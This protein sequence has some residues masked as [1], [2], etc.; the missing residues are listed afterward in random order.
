MN[1]V[2]L[3]LILPEQDRDLF[4]QRLF[5]LLTRQA[6]AYT[7]GESSSTPLE[8]AN[9]LLA[10]LSFTLQNAMECGLSP[11][12]L[13]EEDLN[14]MLVSGRC[15]IQEKST[16][17]KQLWNM[18]CLRLPPIEN[19]SMTDTLKN[20]RAFWRRY[21]DRFFA[22]ELPCDIDYQL[23]LPV[24]P[25]AQGVDYLLLYLKQLT[26][27][28]DFLR[29]YAAKDLL[30]VLNCF[31]PDFHGLLINLYEPVAT[32]AL[33]RS[34]MGRPTCSLD[35]ADQDRHALLRL[36][37]SASREHQTALLRQAARETARRL[38]LPSPDAVR[39]L[40]RYAEESL[41]PRVH[42]ACLHGDLSCLFL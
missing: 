29:H 3:S 5:L 38:K 35:L 4:T 18:L 2:S 7:C 24:S 8:T 32:N 22:H 10:S 16:R 25:G 42:T 28:N 19:R 23:A 39:Y 6:N 21:D 33:G 40:E 14:E 30:P 34:L 9:E 20:I 26:I 13:L 1:E 37:S 27:E 15:R 12:A 11:S 36:F 41:S 31:C 17:A